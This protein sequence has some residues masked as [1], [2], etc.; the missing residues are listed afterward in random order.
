MNYYHHLS[1]KKIKTKTEKVLEE[2]VKSNCDT[3]NDL[4]KSLDK[5][6]KYLD[7]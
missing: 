3:Y 2:V 5:A 7:F 1:V 4:S 6:E